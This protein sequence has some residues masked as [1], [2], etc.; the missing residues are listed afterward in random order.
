MTAMTTR[1][2]PVR[3][4]FATPTVAERVMLAAATALEATAHRRM[5]RR[6]ALAERIAAGGLDPVERRREHML[7]AY[8][9]LN[10]R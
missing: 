3:P 6:Q 8:R 1:A 7:D 2:V 4:L 5:I 10:L 9:R